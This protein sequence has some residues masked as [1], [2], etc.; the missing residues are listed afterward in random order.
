MSVFTTIGRENWVGENDLAFAIRDR[1]AVSPG[2]TLIITKRVTPTWFDATPEEQRAIFELVDRVKADLDAE[3]HPDGY[4]VGFNAGAAAGQTVDHLHV[5]VIP[6]FDGDMDDPRG[7]VRHVIPSKGNYLADAT[8]EPDTVEPPSHDLVTTQGR[9]MLLELLRCF[10]ND[11]FNRIDLLVSFVKRS[12]IKHLLHDLDRAVANGAQ[13]RLLTTNYLAIT[14]ARALRILLNRSQTGEGV[15]TPTEPARGSLEIRV[16]NDPSTSFHPKAYLFTSDEAAVRVGFVGSSNLSDSALTSGVEWNLRTR[17]TA[18][19]TSEFERL[20]SDGRSVVLTH[21][22][23]VGYEAF[24]AERAGLPAPA[25]SSGPTASTLD[26]DIVEDETLED[27][28]APRGVQ[29]DVLA[30]LSATRLDGHQAGLVVMATG[31]GKT[32][33]AAFDVAEVN[34]TRTL[35]VAHRKEILTQA[36]DIFAQV[37][38]DKR[39]SLWV[40]GERDLSGDI[41]FASI[42]GLAG[43]LPQLDPAAFDYVIVDEFHHA[44]APS[45]RRLLVRLRPQFL[46]GLT[47]TPERA[48]GA[49]LLALCSDNLVHDVGLRTGIELGL[50]VPFRYRG[51]VDVADY[52]HIPWRS[53]RFDIDTLSASLAT[54]ARAQQVFDEWL[55][56]GGPDRRAIGFCCSVAHAEFMAEFF[57]ARGVEAV[58]V[59]GT[60]ASSAPRTESLERLRSGDLSIIFTVDLFNEGVDI[61]EVDLVM[62][63]RPT[64][65][66]VVFFQQLGRG[67]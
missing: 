43:V 25:S 49:D 16:F 51:I 64:H 67:L 42:A 28:P 56:I 63:L 62:F 52:T 1:F 55:G 8:L 13:V 48:D 11:E 12:G 37:L 44:D 14:D 17:D 53:R 61:P 50:L 4:N 22:W 46:L 9:R 15:T 18:V 27:V 6:R 3:V 20:W 65:S 39:S 57:T 54:E 29:P 59:H 38:P 30:A 47:A 5:H 23:L 66:P 32:W 10:A 58:A 21:E 40:D 36:R 2:H 34:P 31:L 35:F 60:T 24:Q 7:G 45:Y 33:L 41:V 26:V 19:L